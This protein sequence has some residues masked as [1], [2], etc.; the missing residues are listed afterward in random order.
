MDDILEQFFPTK[1][2]DCND[3]ESSECCSLCSATTR[4]SEDGFMV[5]SNSDCG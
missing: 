5:C 2:I 1:V 3:S 4:L